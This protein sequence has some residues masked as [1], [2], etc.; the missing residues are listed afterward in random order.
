M[1]EIDDSPDESDER[2]SAG[3]FAPPEAE[4]EYTVTLNNT[5]YEMSQE[6]R[7]SIERRAELEYEDNDR[8]SCWWKVASAEDAAESEIHE[9]G[10]PLLVI[11][12]VGV[13]VPWERLD[14]LEVEEQ[15]TDSYDGVD[16]GNGMT[17]VDPNEVND[18]DENQEK[19]RTHFS[20]TPQDFEEVPAPEGEDAQ[21]VPQKPQDFDEP[22]LVMWVPDNPDIEHSWD[23][24]EAIMPMSNWVEWNVQT[25]ADQPRPVR[26]KDSSH[27]HFE[28]LAKSYGCEKVGEVAPAQEPKPDKKGESGSAQRKGDRFD[29]GIASGNNWNV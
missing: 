17:S 19:N 22:S 6:W 27:D 1:T 10:D 26:D 15:T 21:K 13:N 5:V 3:N 14:Q 2:S 4:P 11:E 8:F 23:T 29:E 18:A 7:D 12:T 28:S 25:R 20:V 16:S 24:G 9:V